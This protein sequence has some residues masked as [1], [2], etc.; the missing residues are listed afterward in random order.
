MIASRIL[1][2]LVSASVLL[3]AQQEGILL[4]SRSVSLAGEADLSPG[5]IF[6]DRLKNGADGPEMVI[7]PAGSFE[8]GDH[9]GRYDID[10][11]PVHNVR[12]Q[13]PFA[14]GD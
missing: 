3:V 10:E 4:Q 6:R 5:E 9:E 7:V 11:V 12:I 8:M 13:K 2:A 1:T 14:M